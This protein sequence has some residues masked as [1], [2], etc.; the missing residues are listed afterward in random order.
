VRSIREA[1]KVF[2]DGLHLVVEHT[3][4]VDDQ[5]VRVAFLPVGDT[6]LE[7]LEPTSEEGPVASFLRRRGEGI[8]HVCLEVKDIEAVL[9]ELKKAGIRLVDD[10]PRM[11][12]QGSRIAFL[13]PS[14]THG[15][16]LELH[17]EH[18]CH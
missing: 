3:E 1:L 14:S 8:H 9:E 15:V 4:T 11:G 10:Q 2:R 5:G 6:R 17:E 7:L 13:H 12:A 18:Q 16:L